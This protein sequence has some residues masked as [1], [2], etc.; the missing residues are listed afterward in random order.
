GSERC[1]Q[2][3]RLN[4]W[5]LLPIWTIMMTVLCIPKKNRR[6]LLRE[7]QCQAK[8]AW[9]S[10]S[11]PKLVGLVSRQRTFEN[12]CTLAPVRS[13]NCCLSVARSMPCQFW[14][15]D[16]YHTLPFHC[17]ARAESCATKC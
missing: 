3:G 2:R 10:Y 16:G 7:L 14:W 8:N 11:C 1:E 12:G 5:A 4:C 15:R 6:A 17:W 13:K 9:T